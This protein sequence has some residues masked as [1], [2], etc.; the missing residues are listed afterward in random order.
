MPDSEYFMGKLGG[1][2]QIYVLIM[3]KIRGAHGVRRD[4]KGN[5]TPKFVFQ[6]FIIVKT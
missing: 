4:Q 1:H 6:Q 3:A 5:E 2:V